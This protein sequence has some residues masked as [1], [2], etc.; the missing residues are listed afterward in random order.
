LI[1][2]KKETLLKIVVTPGY[3][4]R[5]DSIERAYYDADTHDE[6]L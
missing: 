1:M 3:L 6:A 4:I 5:N 2:N